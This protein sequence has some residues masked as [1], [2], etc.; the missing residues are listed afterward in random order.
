MQKVITL[1][2]DLSAKVIEEGKKEAAAYDKYA[3]FCKEQASDKLY[4]I[5]KSKKKIA[6][7]TAFIELQETAIAQLNQDISKLSKKISKLEDEIK[8]IT[9]KRE[10]EHAAYLVKAEDMNEAITA[11]ESAIAALKD[12]KKQMKGA[13][14]SSLLQATGGLVKAVSK[15]PSLANVPGAMALLSKLNAPGE[16]TRYQYQSNDIIATLETLLAKFKDMKKELDVEEFEINAAF[17]TNKLGLENEKEFAGKEKAEKEAIAATRSEK[18]EEAKADKDNETKDMNADQSFLDVL[19]KDCEDKAQ[20]FD[21][22][23]GTRA[24]ELKA[25]T[26]ATAALEEG[27]VPNFS[28]NK[29]LVGLQKGVALHKVADTK[30]SPASFLQIRSVQHQKSGKEMALERVLSFLSG[31]ADQSGSAVLYAIAGRIQVA[32]DHFV[33]VRGLIKDLI[34]KLK[35]DAAAEAEQKSMCD[36][37]MGKAI[38]DRDE[39]QANIEVAMGRLTV[40]NAKKEKLEDEIKDLNKA[41]AELKKALLEATELRAEEKADNE[42]TIEMAT[43]GKEAVELALNI[44]KDFYSN[45]FMQTNKYVP[46][47]SDREGNTVGDLAPAVF[48]D[49]YHGAQAESKGI[50]GILEVLLSD[51]E[52][53]IKKTTDEEADAQ[54]AF[55]EFEKD[56]NDEIKEKN[57]RIKDATE[58][59]KTTEADIL[60]QEQA[61][62][63]AKGL[64]ESAAATLKELE[65]MCVAG[66][67]T[68]EARKKAREEEIEALKAALVILDD[69]QK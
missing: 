38:A 53:T 61:L 35:D 33:K 30:T 57:D 54:A 2:K 14:L 37:A 16:A 15:N 8:E 52:R 25:L 7:L 21:Q 55:E 6:D 56:T 1:L 60:D 42:K 5:E 3:C 22:R 50:V 36:K 26:E 65:P 10:K 43:E 24:D 69:W 17:E 41:I 39:A 58:E 51:F 27:A 18:M 12:S 64:L 34:Q 62:K 40:L 4:A 28:A 59:L 48:D 31:R 9:E 63:D 68:W 32:E 46:P 29:K 47:D 13:K 66:E 20:L 44:L 19:T 49:K 23:S 67:E 45:A 11:C